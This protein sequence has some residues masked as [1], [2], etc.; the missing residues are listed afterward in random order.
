MPGAADRWE[1]SE[2]GLT[3]TFHLREGVTFSD[4]TP[5]TVEDVVFSFERLLAGADWGWL[6]ADMS[7]V[8]SIEATGEREFEIVLGERRASF[9]DTLCIHVT[10]IVP[11]K[12]VEEQGEDFWESPVGSGPFM[13]KEW[14]RGDHITLVRNPYY[15]EEGKPYLDEVEIKMVPDDSTRMLKFRGGEL[16]LA[17]RVPPAQVEEID[18]IDGASVQA[19]SILNM[20]DIMLIPTAEP[21]DDPNVRYALN[22]A[23]DKQSIIDTVMFGH[24]TLARHFWPF[25]DKWTNIP[26]PYPYDLDKAREYMAKSKVPDGFPIRVTYGAGMAMHEELATM[27][28]QQWAEIGV[29]VVLEPLDWGTVVGSMWGEGCEYSAVIYYHTSDVLDPFEI[30]PLCAWTSLW[31]CECNEEY[32]EAYFASEQMTGAERDAKWEEIV[33][34]ADEWAVSIPIVH[35]DVLVATWDHVKGFYVVPTAN[36]WLQDV[37]LDK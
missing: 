5:V 35:E 36:F 25:P 9:L 19:F 29:E 33:G 12:L 21:L 16:D 22:H 31:A 26:D 11:K 17:F 28:Q 8:R 15:W 34:I 18:Q 4:G 6:Y 37:W 3:Y 30:S 24:G 23:T 10:S 27:V 32:E 14:V 20:L 13:V 1:I 7:T 2:D